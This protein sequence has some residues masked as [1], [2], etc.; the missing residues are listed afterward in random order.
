MSSGNDEDVLTELSTTDISTPEASDQGSPGA[1]HDSS[2]QGEALLEGDELFSGSDNPSYYIPH[3]RKRS[4]SR[5]SISH[6]LSES[7]LITVAEC[8]GFVLQE[9]L[10]EAFLEK[11]AFS[12]Y[13]RQ[14][15][16]SDTQGMLRGEKA[17]KLV[18]DGSPPSKDKKSLPRSKSGSLIEASLNDSTGPAGKNPVR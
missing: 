11:T 8:S 7:R 4:T 14:R 5:L 18:G 17:E 10:N 15:G 16:Y 12:T 1:T 2:D 13:S 6:S 9:S 3:S